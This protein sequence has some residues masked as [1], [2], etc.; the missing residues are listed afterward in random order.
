MIKFNHL[1]LFSCTYS[2]HLQEPSVEH[3]R[4]ALHT[5]VAEQQEL[6]Q[7]AAHSTLSLGRLHQRLII[8]ERY[9]LALVCKGVVP[10]PAEEVQAGSGEEEEEEEELEEMENGAAEEREGD[11]VNK[12]ELPESSSSR[13]TKS[14]SSRETPGSGVS[15]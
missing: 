7:K 12:P 6:Y 8:M 4:G 1:H 2:T 9:F 15:R 11:E 5:L 10:E 14:V 3:L 13:K